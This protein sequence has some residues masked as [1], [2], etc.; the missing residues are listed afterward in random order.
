MTTESRFEG[1]R[2]LYAGWDA[3]Y[4]RRVELAGRL[5]GAI[6]D[7]FAQF[8]GAPG[9]YKDFKGDIRRYVAAYREI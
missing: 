5:S 3:D 1:L 7:G 8:L 6:A 2:N 9:S 4:R